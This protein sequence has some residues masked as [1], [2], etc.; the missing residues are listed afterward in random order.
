M[1]NVEK[2]YTLFEIQNVDDIS[3][4]NIHKKWKKLCLKYHPDKNIENT[5]D[6]FIEIQE[7]YKILLNEKQKKINFQR[8][9]SSKKNYED[10]IYEVMLKLMHVDNLKKIVNWLYNDKKN[11]ENI[12]H[13]CFDQV[14]NKEIY[15]HDGLYIPLWHKKI[16]RHQMLY[17]GAIANDYNDLFV[18]HVENIRRNVML[19]DNNDILIYMKDDILL[20]KD[21]NVKV[22]VSES[23]YYMFRLSDIIRKNRYHILLNKGIPKIDNH[24]I[25]NVSELS[26]I[27]ICFT[28]QINHLPM[29]L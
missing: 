3:I 18:I 23:T 5:S 8:H 27:I 10:I 21:D 2:S 1:T 20:R 19:L 24:N 14:L 11:C 15:P 16:Y 17:D 7:A 9:Q 13:V 12:L 28:N 29:H 26:N 25:Y 4:D 6:K 22:Y